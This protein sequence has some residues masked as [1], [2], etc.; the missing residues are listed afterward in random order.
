MENYFDFISLI[1]DFIQLFN[2]LINIE[3]NKLN[4][5]IENKV[6]FMEEC[7]NKEQALV[8]RLK[9][10][11]QRRETLQCSMD[12]EN[13]TFREILDKVPEDVHTELSPLFDELSQKVRTFQSVNDNARDMIQLNLYKIHSATPSSLSGTEETHFTNRFV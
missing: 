2:S 11:E 12:M 8:L 9:G 4:Y 13:L 5:V 6:S 10:L 3:Q 7:V 1:K